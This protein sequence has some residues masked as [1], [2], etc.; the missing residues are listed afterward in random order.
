MNHHKQPG[1]GESW[2]RG[3]QCHIFRCLL[4]VMNGGGCGIDD[5]VVVLFVMVW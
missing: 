2:C 4:D 1:G 3:G 5:F